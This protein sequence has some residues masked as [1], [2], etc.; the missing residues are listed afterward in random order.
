[1]VPPRQIVRPGDNAYIECT[2]TGQQ[3]I[4]IRWLPVGRSLPPSV[5]TREGLIQFNNIQLSDAGRYRCTAVSSA[6]EADA[7]ADVIV[8]GISKSTKSKVDDGTCFFL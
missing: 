8:E 4:S 6:G 2:A 1:L 7:V 5:T 3:P